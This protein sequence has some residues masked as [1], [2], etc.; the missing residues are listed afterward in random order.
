MWLPNKG[1]CVFGR[2]ARGGGNIIKLWFKTWSK[3]DSL[4]AEFKNP[5]TRKIIDDGMLQA[6][7]IKA[8]LSALYEMLSKDPM[9]TG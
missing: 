6:L 8:D 7:G 3:L 5:R 2:L 4:P 9:I 1:K